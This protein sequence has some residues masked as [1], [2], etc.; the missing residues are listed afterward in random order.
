LDTGLDL[1][2]S[3]V[4]HDSV[5]ALRA[6][7]PTV[8]SNLD[9]LRGEVWVVDNLCAERAA[10]M[11]QAE[12]PHVQVLANDAVLGF[13]ANHNQVI[14]RSLKRSRYIF[15]LNPD[16]RLPPGALRRMVACLDAHPATGVLGVNVAYE[17]GRVQ[18]LPREVIHLRRDLVMLAVYISHWP[19]LLSWLER[20][21]A[22]RRGPTASATAPAARGKPRAEAAGE[23][24]EPSRVVSGAA[25]M[26]RSAA[27]QQVGLFDEAFFLYFEE[28]DWCYRARQAGWEVRT[29]PGVEIIHTGGCSTT[30][31]DYFHYFMIR[32]ESWVRFYR[33]HG[34]PARWH[35]LAGWMWLLAGLNLAH[36][37][38]AALLWPAK[39]AT[40][41]ARRQFLRRLLRHDWHKP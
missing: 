31:H 35:V 28:Y 21:N 30:R 33:K 36:L 22:R 4:S 20:V 10:P 11:L 26:L 24:P 1:V 8:M 6:C 25:L 19:G 18:P 9:G 17:D 23:G 14:G 13:A 39:A 7:L 41:H 37:R 34:G 38:L 2:V 27:V 29:L 15:V 5:E 32:L 12:F 3:I 16:T 40:H